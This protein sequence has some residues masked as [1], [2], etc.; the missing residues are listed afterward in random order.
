MD[1]SKFADWVSNQVQNGE[2]FQFPW[3]HTESIYGDLQLV[4]DIDNDAQT[5]PEGKR[6]IIEDIRIYFIY[7]LKTLKS[8]S[9]HIS[10][11][12]K[13]TLWR[14]LINQILWCNFNFS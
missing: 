8:Y 11:Y 13:D 12:F 9:Y 2:I 14:L 3:V 4:Q 6:R 5:N 10:W 7:L 1:H